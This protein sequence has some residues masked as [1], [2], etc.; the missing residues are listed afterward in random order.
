MANIW[1]MLAGIFATAT[2]VGPIAA[3]LIL[4]GSL[5]SGL[6]IVRKWFCA[7]SVLRS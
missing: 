1:I 5:L 4:S 3:A 7:F 2:P 6:A